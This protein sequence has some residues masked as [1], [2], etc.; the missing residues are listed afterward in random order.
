MGRVRSIIKDRRYEW[1]MGGIREDKK[2][3]IRS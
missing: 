1:E 3:E 2:K